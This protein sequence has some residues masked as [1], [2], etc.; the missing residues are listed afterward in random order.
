M[1]QNPEA[2]RRDIEDTQARIGDTVEALAYKTDVPARAR[3]AVN[4]RVDA[5]KGK[6]SG[7]VST[8]GGAAGAVGDAI[9]DATS[10][11]KD[12]AANAVAAIPS[13]SQAVRTIGTIASNNPL[14][15]AIGSIAA[16]FLIGLCLPVSDIERDRVGR[17]GE[18]MTDKAK[19][20]AADAVEQGKAAVTQAIGDAISGSAHKQA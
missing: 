9:G 2:I 20:A 4:D 18:Q 1:D 6:I 15:L 14:G 16:G 19:S 8:A 5:I 13:P 11:V 3:D 12:T 10:S 17:I 7:A